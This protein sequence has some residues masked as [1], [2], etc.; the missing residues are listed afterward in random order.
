MKRTL[1]IGLLAAL[2]L[3]GAG[4]L[5]LLPTAHQLAQAQAPTNTPTSQAAIR[6]TSKDGTPTQVPILLL[7]FSNSAAATPGFTA[8]PTS[9][10]PPAP[11][12]VACILPTPIPTVVV[13]VSTP[14]S[15]TP[16]SS[17]D[18]F[19]CDESPTTNFGNISTMSLND[20]CSIMIHWPLAAERMAGRVITR[21]T[22]RLFVVGQPVHNAGAS[23]FFVNPMA[24]RWTELGASWNRARSGVTWNT[25]GAR[26]ANSDYLAETMG[27]MEVNGTTAG[28]VD[29]ELAPSRMNTWRTANNYG[30]IIWSATA[31]NSLRIASSEWANPAFRPQ[32]LLEVD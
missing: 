1:L 4:V 24:V 20:G 11:T 7:G 12:E 29:I 10:P 17:S 31:Q 16:L 18:T 13:G 30:L 28:W 25:P 19:I 22:L 5:F 9:P 32:L 14:G 26:G 2:L 6:F 21:A 27:Y 3:I 8:T 23:V 15:S